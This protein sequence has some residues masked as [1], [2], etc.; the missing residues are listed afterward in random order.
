METKESHGTKQGRERNGLF[1][2]WILTEIAEKEE[3][4][5][6]APDDNNQNNLPGVWTLWGVRCFGLG[7]DDRL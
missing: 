4:K 5:E 1:P 2:E 7:L 6:E 3:T